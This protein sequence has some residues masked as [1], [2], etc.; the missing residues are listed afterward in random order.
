MIKKKKKEVRNYYRLERPNNRSADS[1]LQDFG[2]REVCQA[3][4]E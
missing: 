4:K 3:H 2:P 1:S